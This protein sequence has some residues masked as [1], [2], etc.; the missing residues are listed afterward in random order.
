MLVVVG[1]MH[2]PLYFIIIV[3]IT[4]VIITITFIVNIIFIIFIIIRT[5]NKSSL[6]FL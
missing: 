3:I 6:L 2:L 1:V 4:I 5:F